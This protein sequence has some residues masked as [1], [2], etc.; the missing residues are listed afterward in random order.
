MG[1]LVTVSPGGVGRLDVD[2]VEAIA[3]LGDEL[4]ALGQPR[5][6]LGIDPVG[7]RGDQHVLPVERFDQRRGGNTACPRG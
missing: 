2:I 6:Q 7:D 4:H 1:V 5:D 3:E